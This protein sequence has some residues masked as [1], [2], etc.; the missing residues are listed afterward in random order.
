MV[1]P[2]HNETV[3]PVEECLVKLANAT[4]NAVLVLNADINADSFAKVVS[5][6]D[7]IGTQKA[8]SLIL[9]SRGGSIDYAFGIAKAIRGRCQEFEVI[10][11]DIAKSAATLI[12]LAADRIL[13]GQ[14]GEL[15]PLDP[16]VLDRA[17]GSGRRS[18][19]EIVK[20]LEYLRDYYIETFD[21]MV[22]LLLGRAGMDVPHTMEHATGALSSI[23]G[24]LYNSVNYRELGEAVRH[25]TVSQ[26]YANE[27]M[28][29][30]SPLDQA[31]FEAVVETL[32]WEY[33]DHG[34]IIDVDEARNIGLSNVKPLGIEL[35]ALYYVVVDREES[36]V[37]YALPEGYEQ[38]EN[39]N[40]A[41]PAPGGNH[42]STTGSS[43]E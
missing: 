22:R 3:D 27:T 31:S 15:G 9:N 6:L 37:C 14:F 11:P 21:L 26:Q 42:G 17:G 28:R 35:E 19:L 20:G 7:N 2:E 16:Q 13:L 18:P 40:D 33:P 38:T 25:L 10:V 8:L 5:A 41:A 30:W 34:F 4:G 36:F 32:V 1:E 24:A 12:T 29:R 23:A 43:C 39:G